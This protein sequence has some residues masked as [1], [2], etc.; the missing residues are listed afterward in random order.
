MEGLTGIPTAATDWLGALLTS[1][2]VVASSR[3]F[4][5]D[6]RKLE[7]ELETLAALFA[8]AFLHSCLFA[9]LFDTILR[10]LSG[11][12]FWAALSLGNGRIPG[13]A[14]FGAGGPALIGVVAFLVAPAILFW[15]VL[16][17][18]FMLATC[19]WYSILRGK[20]LFRSLFPAAPPSLAAALCVY[21]FH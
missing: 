11:V 7:I 12:L 9:A 21:M 15:A 1:G 18:A 17:C 2:M 3:L 10:L 4:L 14:K 20:R 5:I 8:L 16:S 19:A 6:L 13:L